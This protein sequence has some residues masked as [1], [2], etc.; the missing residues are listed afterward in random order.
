MNVEQILTNAQKA[1]L[2]EV[3]TNPKPGLVD[4]V[5]HGA[6]PDMDIY[7]FIDS[8]EA[9]RSYLEQCCHL[10]T[11]HTGTMPELFNAL[12]VRGIVAERTMFAATQGVN[13]HK[14]AIFSLGIFVAASAY[15][16]RTQTDFKLVAVQD[17]IRAML[18]NL[19]QD[20]FA[21]LTHKKQLTAGEQQ[22]L[23]Y[24]KTGIR[25]QAAAGYPAVTR[26]V[27]FL[28]QTQGTRQEKI[29]DTLMYLAGQVEDSNLVKRAH[30]PAI[31][32]WMQARVATY[33][34]HGGAQTP[35]GLNYLKE[36]EQLFSQR[37][38]S[39]GG[40]ADL[41]IVTIYCGLMEGIL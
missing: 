7:T 22:Y 8:S 27:E 41:L 13:T 26:G 11:A 14:G 24:G 2:Y 38:Y 35:A 36:L 25:G 31:Q 3:T 28:R 10:A 15:L 39:L 37:K 29:L 30:N 16:T 4:P 33:F 1:L 9:M 21:N 18:V 20:D 6:H 23:K 12:R 40:T 32:Q 19:L 34:A 5:E 17:V